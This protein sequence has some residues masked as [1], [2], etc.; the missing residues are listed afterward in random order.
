MDRYTQ[1]GRLRALPPYVFAELDRVCKPGTIFAT[2]TSSFKVADM[3]A[4]THRPHLVAGLHYFFP[5]LINKLLEVTQTA[6]TPPEVVDALM[7][8]ARRRA[9]SPS[10]CTMRPALR[11]IASYRIR[12]LAV[13][14]STFHLFQGTAAGVPHRNHWLR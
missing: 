10:L 1:A 7:N 9:R 11:S 3:A 12:E 14:G 2:N 6:E 8:L 5:A 4:Q 13:P